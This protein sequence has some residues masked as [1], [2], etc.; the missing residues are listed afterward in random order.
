[1]KLKAKTTMNK[2]MI[3]VA[4][5]AL[6]LVAGCSNQAAENTPT[7]QTESVTPVQIEMSKLGTV[8]SSAGFTAKLAPSQ[9]VQLSPKLSGKITSLPVR[10]GQYV[11]QGETLFSV[12]EQDVIN[13]IKQAEAAYQVAKANLNQAGNSSSQGL[14]QA[15]NSLSQAQTALQDA[16]RNQQRMQTLFNQGAIALQQYEQAN[17]QLANAR[18]A[19]ANA[20]EGLKAATQMSAV[21]VSEASVKQAAVSLENARTQLGNAV[22]KAPFSGYISSV[23]GAVG[24]V[25][26][27]QSPIVT[28]VNTNPLVVKANLS[29]QDISQVK[30]GDEVKV[31]IT[32]LGKEMTAKVTAVSP[33]MDQQL[34]AYPIEISIPNPN[35][36]LK[37]DMVVNM[38]LVGQQ[39]K[40]QEKVVV[41]RKAVFDRDGKQYVYIVEGEIAKQ[42]AV[43]TG[44]GSSESI[45]ILTGIKADQQVVVK[46][47]T[48]LKD[49]S[50]VTIQK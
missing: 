15:K 17:T 39:G 41:P 24:Q 43:T 25:A 2:K 49:G 14:E 6:F 12:D 42:V 40:G 11:K 50:K 20:Q 45:E 46:G 18:T 7:E 21:G 13:S 36:E 4:A 3:L 5:S 30:V 33:V 34:K 29:E 37:A 1:M 31:N 9:D 26:S 38:N 27:P 32:A 48:L 35:N 10:L 16:E 22:V 8:S 28:L 44:E 19:V 47:Q 23:N